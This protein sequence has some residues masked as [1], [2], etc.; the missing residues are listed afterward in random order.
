[1]KRLAKAFAESTESTFN[2][3]MYKDALSK[4]SALGAD[5]RTMDHETRA[6]AINDLVTLTSSLVAIQKAEGGE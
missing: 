3:W 5:L 1:M 6:W 2:P 4:M